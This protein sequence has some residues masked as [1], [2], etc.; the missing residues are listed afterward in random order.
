MHCSVF[1][2]QRVK[3]TC[4]GENVLTRSRIPAGP[5]EL[6]ATDIGIL[7]DTEQIHQHSITLLTERFPTVQVICQHMEGKS[8]APYIHVYTDVNYRPNNARDQLVNYSFIFLIR[9]GRREV[10]GQKEKKSW[11]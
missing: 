8:R 10:K 7:P 4:V 2:L 3:K 11:Q 5:W 6:K 9:K 1:L